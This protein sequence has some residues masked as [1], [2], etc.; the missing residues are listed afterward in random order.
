[1]PFFQPPKTGKARRKI[2]AYYQPTLRSLETLLGDYR[3]YCD[4]RAEGEN[5]AATAET[6]ITMKRRT[7]KGQQNSPAEQRDVGEML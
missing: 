7:Q 1:M 5:I 2:K 3:E 6:P 4:T